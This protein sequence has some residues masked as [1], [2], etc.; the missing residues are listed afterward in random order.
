MFSCESGT[1]T[2]AAYLQA[3]PVSLH[4]QPATTNPR[5]WVTGA[6]GAIAVAATAAAVRRRSNA[7]MGVQA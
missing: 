5:L 3:M 2:T 1:G 7:D 6:L 4:K